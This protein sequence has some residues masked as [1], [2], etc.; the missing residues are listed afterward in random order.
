MPGLPDALLTEATFL[1]QLVVRKKKG[2]TI[3]AGPRRTEG[4]F[5]PG[6]WTSGQ[7]GRRKALCRARAGGKGRGNGRRPAR[8]VV[9]VIVAVFVFDPHH[10]QGCGMNG[11][12]DPPPRV[13]ATVDLIAAV[14][15]LD[16]ADLPALF[17]R[18]PGNCLARLP[19][20]HRHE[21][22]VFGAHGP[23]V[24]GCEKGQNCQ[25]LRH[26]PDSGL[27]PDELHI[28]CEPDGRLKACQGVRQPCVRLNRQAG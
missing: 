27:R 21:T 15:D 19:V 4:T 5:G 7:A 3:T 1:L 6:G 26:G 23:C 28:G 20:G 16:T 10:L 17:R 25:C 12:L 2:P 24:K 13:R 11:H 18:H 9:V 8:S 22:I 14:V